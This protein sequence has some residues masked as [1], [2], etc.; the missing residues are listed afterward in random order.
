MSLP[1]KVVKTEPGIEDLARQWL[2]IDYVPQTKKVVQDLLDAG[3]K[4]VG[5]PSPPALLVGA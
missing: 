3:D 5:G 1:T 4:P 2:E